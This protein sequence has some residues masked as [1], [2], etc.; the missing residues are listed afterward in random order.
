MMLPGETFASDDAG[1]SALSWAG[2]WPPPGF[3][4]H[5]IE[6]DLPVVLAGGAG[7]PHA[8]DDRA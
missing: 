8:G 7:G 6:F 3:V 1:I 4:H 5:H 2:N